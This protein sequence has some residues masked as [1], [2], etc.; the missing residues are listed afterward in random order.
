MR[1]GRNGGKLKSG[2][3]KNVGRPPKL[4]QLDVLLDAVLGEEKDGITA[5]EAILKALR[6]KAAKGDVRAAEI[7]LDRAYGKSKQSIDHTT[8]GEAITA[9][10]IQWVD[11]E[12]D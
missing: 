8:K 12:T 10:P 4:P 5:A 6:M 11:N 9:P 7:L 1:E 3:T 2:N